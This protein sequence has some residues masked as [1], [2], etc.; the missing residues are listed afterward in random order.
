MSWYVNREDGVTT[1]K[2]WPKDLPYWIRQNKGFIA[3]CREGCSLDYM[4]IDTKRG[5][6]AVYEYPL[7]EWN[8]CYLVEFAKRSNDRLIWDKWDAFCCEYDNDVLQKGSKK[9]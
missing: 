1:F 5:T 8:S 3:D 2:L 9:K 4:I 6:A 7:N